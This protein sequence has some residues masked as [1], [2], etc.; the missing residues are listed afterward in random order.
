MLVSLG[1]RKRVED[2]LRQLEQQK[3]YPLDMY[4]L[5]KVFGYFPTEEGLK[6][7]G[8]E[9]AGYDS[10]TGLDL[11][12]PAHEAERIQKLLFAYSEEVKQ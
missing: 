2:K 4:E 11:Y 12:A 7:F 1:G 3:L 8:W 10:Q 6:E 9:W 5:L